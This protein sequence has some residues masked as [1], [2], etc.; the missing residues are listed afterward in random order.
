MIPLVVK[1]R[2]LVAA[3]SLFNLTLTATM[4]GGF[5]VLGPVLLATV[6]HNNFGGLYF[7][8]F[9]LCIAAA[10]LTYFLPDVDPG[11]SAAARRKRGEKV[12]VGSVAAGATDI[13]R[14]GFH[15]AWDELVEGWQFIRRDPVIISAIIYWSIAIAVFMMLGTVGPG[16]LEKV[17]SLLWTTPSS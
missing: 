6:F 17:Y 10:V 9:L 13:A 14:S 16:F 5:V 12:D 11:E 3:N 2:E 1:R 8:I 4:L 15:T 7:V